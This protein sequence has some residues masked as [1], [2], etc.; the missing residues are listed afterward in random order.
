MSELLARMQEWLERMGPV[1]AAVGAVLVLVVL[2]GLRRLFRRTVVPS[3]ITTARCACGWTG[4]VSKL[5][6]ICPRCANEIKLSR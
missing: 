6:P 4:Q 5:K 1:R 2:A 3:H